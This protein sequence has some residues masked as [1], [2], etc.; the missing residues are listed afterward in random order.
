MDYHSQ[1]GNM[2]IPRENLKNIAVE[3]LIKK[4]NISPGKINARINDIKAFRKK[5]NI[6]VPLSEEELRLE[7]I[8][9]DAAHENEWSAIYQQ[10]FK[11]EENNS[12]GEG[13]SLSFD[14]MNSHDYSEWLN[15]I[16]AFIKDRTY[17]QV[18]DDDGSFWRL[19]VKDGKIHRIFPSWDMD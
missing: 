5:Y 18:S 12:L 16:E 9:D 11:D 14:T 17:I 1:G 7:A 4:Y 19:V 3:Q 15:I 6:I 8:L 10:D 13:V 2:F